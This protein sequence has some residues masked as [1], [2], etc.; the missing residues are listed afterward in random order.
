M[1]KYICPVIG[2]SWYHSA[3]YISFFRKT[4]GILLC[5]PSQAEFEAWKRFSCR[6]F[7]LESYTELHKIHILCLESSQHHSAIY[8]SFFF[9]VFL[10]GKKK[11]VVPTLLFFSGRVWEWKRCSHRIFILYS[12]TDSCI[13]P[14]PSAS[15]LRNTTVSSVYHF[16]ILCIFKWRV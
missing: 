9:S 16:L 11:R 3:I 13:K 12:Y 10:S 5:S 6:I 1:P 8:L 7:I 4:C 15:S 14:I 2:H